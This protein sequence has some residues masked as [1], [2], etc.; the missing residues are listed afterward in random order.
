MQ[1]PESGV[2]MGDW[3]STREHSYQSMGCNLDLFSCRHDLIVQ[4][5]LSIRPV[6]CLVEMQALASHTCLIWKM[7]H[8]DVDTTFS[9]SRRRA[10]YRDAKAET[11]IHHLRVSHWANNYFACDYR[12]HSDYPGQVSVRKTSYTVKISESPVILTLGSEVAIRMR[13]FRERVIGRQPRRPSQ[14]FAQSARRAV[15]LSSGYTV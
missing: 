4:N 9:S 13:V 1:Q 14:Y 12:T 6:G 10:E 15:R 5:M 11:R 7:R 8:L 2:N 3:G